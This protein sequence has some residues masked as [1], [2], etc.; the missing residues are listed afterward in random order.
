MDISLLGFIV[1][2][3]LSALVGLIA[4]A[5][6]GFHGGGLL[7]AIGLGF[8]GG[9]VG[10]IL[11][12][13]LGGPMILAVDLGGMTFPV[14][15]ALLGTILLVALVAVVTRRTPLTTHRRRTLW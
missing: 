12:N 9:L 2:I 3:A 5:I 14:V 13:A 6:V 15:W 4:K 11:A 1:L 10:I 8:V 7:A